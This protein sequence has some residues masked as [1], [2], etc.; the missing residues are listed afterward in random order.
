M[1]KILP[2]YTHLTPYYGDIHNHC[3]VGYG[4]G[5]FGDALYNAQ[6][7]LDFAAVT[8]HA[9]WGDMPA[10]D[11]RLAAAVAYHQKGFARTKLA[12]HQVQAAVEGAYR[13]GHFVTFLAH[14]WHSLAYGDH[15]I[16]YKEPPGEIL[17]EPDLPALRRRLA[18]YRAQGR[19]V[20][21]LPHHIGYHQGYRGINWAT[22][23]EAFSPVVE[24]YSMHG[25]SESADA[26]YPYLHTMGP[27]DWQS[28]YHYGLAPCPSRS[29]TA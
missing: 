20:M 26:P 1:K 6:L 2:P 5:S 7:Q 13:P 17:R 8:V 22:Y 11:E 28:T 12:W 27:R 24:I 9:H 16:Y 4:H 29:S 10:A 23:D 18:E 3:A 21:V 15:N 25:A 19:E 14:E